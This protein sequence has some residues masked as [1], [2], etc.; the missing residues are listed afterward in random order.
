MS[1][2]FAQTRLSEYLDKYGCIFFFF[3]FLDISTIHNK[4][5]KKSEP[6]IKNYMPDLTA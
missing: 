5:T 6:P 4:N 3:F 1:T 2:L